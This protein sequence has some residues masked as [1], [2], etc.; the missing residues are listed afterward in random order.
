MRQFSSLQAA[1]LE[2]D[3]LEYK[4]ACRTTDLTNL[5]TY[6]GSHH[7]VVYADVITHLTFGSTEPT[8]LVGKQTKTKQ[9]EKQNG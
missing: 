3:N 9:Q 5:L 7:P 1:C 4:L 2:V 6:L 8:L